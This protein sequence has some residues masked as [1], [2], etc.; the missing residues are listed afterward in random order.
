ME[1]GLDSKRRRQEQ[2]AKQ[3]CLCFHSEFQQA[4]D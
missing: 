4:P 3:E 2:P 1:L